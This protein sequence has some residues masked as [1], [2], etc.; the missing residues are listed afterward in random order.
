MKGFIVLDLD[1]NLVIASSFIDC[2]V[3][4]KFHVTSVADYSSIEE[5]SDELRLAAARLI[6]TKHTYNLSRDV[7]EISAA[8]VNAI[9]SSRLEKV[10]LR[11][12]IRASL[13]GQ[14]S[15][16]KAAVEQKVHEWLVPAMALLPYLSVDLRMFVRPY[17]IGF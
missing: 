17:V 4:K 13:L 1:S 14:E 6:L 10:A 12:W 16:E 3:C 2:P 9:S 8:I 5:V 11:Y 15:F 7:L